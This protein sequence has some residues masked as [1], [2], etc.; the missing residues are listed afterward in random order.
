MQKKEVTVSK[1]LQIETSVTAKQN[2]TRTNL[3]KEIEQWI[4]PNICD[5]KYAISSW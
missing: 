1:K 4:L 2:K 3:W 5:F